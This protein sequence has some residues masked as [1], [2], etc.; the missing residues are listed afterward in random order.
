MA[1]ANLTPV[2][3]EVTAGLPYVRKIRVAGATTFW[4]SDDDYE[5]RSQVREA[6][7]PTARLVYD[8]GQHL[9]GQIEGSDLVIEL[10]MT[11]AQTRDLPKGYY[12]IVVSDIGTVDARAL[13]VLSGK[14]RVSSLITAASDE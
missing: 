8:L 2:D 11:G 13:R 9:T 14:V 6:K 10:R 7:A 4:V 3:L 1:G 12:D 5:I